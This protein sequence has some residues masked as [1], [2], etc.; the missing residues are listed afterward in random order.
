V[1]YIKVNP[2]I[3][4]FDAIRDEKLDVIFDK[5]NWVE[6]KDSDWKRLKE[7]QTKQGELLLPNFV[8]KTDGM[9]EIKNFT[10][11]EKVEDEVSDDE[12]YDNPADTKVE[13]E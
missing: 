3:R 12:W 9:G 2:Y 5:N 1:K 11:A 13:E 6:V 4:V 8:E 7:A 10:A